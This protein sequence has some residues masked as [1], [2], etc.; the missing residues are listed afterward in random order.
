MHIWTLKEIH[1]PSHIQNKDEMLVRLPAFL[2]L[3]TQNQNKQLI[4]EEA[5]FNRAGSDS[6]AWAAS[7][8]TMKP[9]L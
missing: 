5:E 6:D 9:E 4:F 2:Y 1:L 8:R 7:L 3:I